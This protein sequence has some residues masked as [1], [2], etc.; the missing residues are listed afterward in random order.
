MKPSTWI[1]AGLLAVTTE[2]TGCSKKHVDTSDL[3]QV[4]QTREGAAATHHDASSNQAVTVTV[5]SSLEQAVAAIKAEDY[6]TAARQLQVLRAQ[7]TLTAQQLTAVQDTMAV[8][9]EKLVMKIEQGDPAALEAAEELRR[10][11]RAQRQ[12]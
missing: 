2:G 8:V 7:P 10:A 11:H 4:F 1:L 6:P 9:Q 5:Q 12:R 3:T